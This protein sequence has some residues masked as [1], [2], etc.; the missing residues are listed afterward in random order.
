[1]TS[2]LLRL[3]RIPVRVRTAP[4]RRSAIRHLTGLAA[5]AALASPPVLAQGVPP[6]VGMAEQAVISAPIVAIDPATQS[7]TVRGPNGNLYEV[8]S[9]EEVKNFGQI[10]VGDMLTIARGE[11]I[12]AGLEPIGSKDTALSESVERTTRAGEGSKPG[13]MREITTT[14]T[15]EV[16]NVDTARR[17]ISFRGPRETLRTV[18]VNRP[19]IDLTQIRKGQMARIVVREVEAIAVLA[20]PARPQ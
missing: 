5:L 20:P 2:R 12:V 17:T 6:P 16:T 7:V 1:M 11:A 10:R 13:I 19:D 3:T 4:V 15:A 9:G 14:V 18:K 8:V